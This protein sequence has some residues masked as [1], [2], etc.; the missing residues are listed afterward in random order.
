MHLF[1]KIKT[2]YHRLPSG[3]YGFFKI[4]GRKFHIEEPTTTKNI[5]MRVSKNRN[6]T[7]STSTTFKLW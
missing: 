1:C 3:K 5:N 4:G 6:T 2:I 7:T